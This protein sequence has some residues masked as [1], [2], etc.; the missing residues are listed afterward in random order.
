MSFISG[1][2][3]QEVNLAGTDWVPAATSVGHH[4]HRGGRGSTGV[5]AGAVVNPGL[6]A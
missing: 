2:A 6:Y 4:A 1:T 5:I 3:Q